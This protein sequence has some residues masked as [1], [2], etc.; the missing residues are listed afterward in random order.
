MSNDS[1][2]LDRRVRLVM[3][4]RKRGRPPTGFR[5]ALY[6]TEQYRELRQSGLSPWRAINQ[7]AAETGRTPQHIAACR[8]MIEDTH[9]SEYLYDPYDL[10]M[11]GDSD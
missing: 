7:V 3:P 9:P 8:K 4:P 11:T 2:E 6:Y 1:D 5:N 10:V